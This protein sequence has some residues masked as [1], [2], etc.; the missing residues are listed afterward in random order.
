MGSGRP[1]SPTWTM[2]IS[3]LRFP[4]HAQGHVHLYF[5]RLTWRVWENHP[6]CVI[7]SLRREDSREK[8]AIVLEDDKGEHLSTGCPSVTTFLDAGKTPSSALSPRRKA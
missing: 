6:L 2:S 8:V 1:M 4:V 7:A 5:P 3:R